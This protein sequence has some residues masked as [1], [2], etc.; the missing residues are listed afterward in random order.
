MD[1]LQTLIKNY[2]EY[3]HTQ[4]GL[5]KKTLKAYQIDL[6]QFS[7]YISIS[8]TNQVTP[9]LLE[10]Y[11]AELHQ[12]YKPKTAKRKIASIKALFHYFEYKEIVEQN[13]FSKLQLHFREPVILPKI[14]PLD[15]LETLLI[16]IYKQQQFA[17]TPYQKRNALRDAAIVELLFVTGMRISELCSLKRDSINLHNGTVLIYGKGNKERRVQIGNNSVI[18]I[19][20][21]YKDNF[22]AEIENSGYFFTNQSGK[23]LSDQTVRRMINKYT[24]LA[25]IEQHIT[26]HMFRHTFATSLLEADVDIRFIQEMLGHSSITVTEI[27]THVEVAKQKD[28]LTKKHPRKD[29]HI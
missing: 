17:K 15:T 2:L 27:Y 1:N 22:I 24:A 16:M 7:D 4:K 18:H 11:I 25:S 13:P 21:K 19:L 14:I 9:A 26:P 10:T 3:C 5:D 8:N 28:I 12:K 29:F 6:R 20:K 23:V